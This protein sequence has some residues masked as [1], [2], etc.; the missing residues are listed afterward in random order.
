MQQLRP[1]TAQVELP[2]ESDSETLSVWWSYKRIA[3]SLKRRHK[4]GQ[5]LQLHQMG[6][7]NLAWNKMDIDIIDNLSLSKC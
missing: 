2:Y 6:L 3:A 4:V 7:L 1:R 5:P